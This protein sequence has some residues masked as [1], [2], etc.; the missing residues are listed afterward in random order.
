M[1]Y[2]ILDSYDL[3]VRHCVE[4]NG[5]SSQSP[6]NT[7]KELNDA[8]K[9]SGGEKP[10]TDAMMMSMSSRHL[11]VKEQAE[12]P[13]LHLIFHDE[14]DG[15]VA[16]RG[17][18]DEV[19]RA[20]PEAEL[21]PDVNEKKLS[22]FIKPKSIKRAAVNAKIWNG[23]QRLT[24]KQL[25]PIVFT[26]I[27]AL[28]GWVFTW[29]DITDALSITIA[30]NDLISTYALIVLGLICSVASVALL[31]AAKRE[32]F[33]NDVEQFE[34]SIA[35]DTDDTQFDKLLMGL[36]ESDFTCFKSGE[37]SSVYVI[38]LS[39]RAIYSKRKRK[40]I[41]RYLSVM[42]SKQ[43]WFVF[44]EKL[45]ENDALLSLDRVRIYTLVHLGGKKKRE[46]AKQVLEKTGV[47]IYES[48][49]NR[50]GVDAI[51]L[52]TVS[53]GATEEDKN[54]WKKKIEDFAASKSCNNIRVDTLVYFVADL[55]AKYHI[56]FTQPRLWQYLFRYGNEGSVVEELDREL[57]SLL[58][59]KDEKQ[60]F[61]GIVRLIEY[62]NA[63]FSKDFAFLSENNPYN[64]KESTEYVQLC[65]IKAL[66]VK[67]AD[68]DV[69]LCNIAL[70]ILDN[71]Y[72]TYRLVKNE[73]EYGAL[74]DFSQGVWGRVISLALG[75]FEEEN[76]RWFSP[77]I[78]HSFLNLYRAAPAH[79]RPL[80][81]LSTAE[82]L[83]A[84]R[85]NLILGPNIHG[86]EADDL[87]LRISEEER[88]GFIDPVY[89]HYLTVKFAAEETKR[90]EKATFGNTPN[91]FGIL[92]MSKSE[93]DEYYIALS[94]LG[95]ENVLHF[96]S[97]LYDTF[98]ACSRVLDSIKY[99]CY[100]LYQNDIAAK[101]RL[102]EN[103][104]YQSDLGYVSLI[105]DKMFSIIKDIYKEDERILERISEI[106]DMY[107]SEDER[108]NEIIL[109]ELAASE[110]SGISLFGYLICM[111]AR[112][113]GNREILQNMYLGIG[114]YLVRFIFLMY[115]ESATNDI[116]NSD[117]KYMVLI[118][119]TYADPSDAILGYLS[120]CSTRVKTDVTDGMIKSYLSEH[121]D[122]CV[123][124][125]ETVAENLRIDDYEGYISN[126]YSISYLSDE[127]TNKI[128][129]R[130]AQILLSTKFTRNE[131]VEL[132]IE[133]ATLLSEGKMSEKF[134]SLADG[135]L[136]GRLNSANPNSACIAYGEYIKLDE[137]RFLPLFPQ[138]AKKILSSSKVKRYD[139]FIRYLNNEMQTDT[140]TEQGGELI[141]ML[142]S[143]WFLRVC[144]RYRISHD[145]ISARRYLHFLIS[146]AKFFNIT[147]DLRMKQEPIRKKL[148]EEFSFFAELE[149]NERFFMRR[150][151]KTS[152]VNLI[153]YLLK[154][155]YLGTY[156]KK[157]AEGEA[158]TAEQIKNGAYYEAP[159]IFSNGEN[160]VNFKYL[161]ILEAI[162]KNE[163]DVQSILDEDAFLEKLLADAKEIIEALLDEKTARRMTERLERIHLSSRRF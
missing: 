161:E 129:R 63:E 8:K 82:F 85:S 37:R 143:D 122:E 66:R 139:F 14:K 134:A 2:S 64:G 135:E 24:V 57:T 142:I 93:R 48:E 163:Q 68:D 124:N 151:E 99:S 110:F 59:F 128:Y 106:H 138:V 53:S 103:T 71:I 41:R 39:D 157:S 112:I 148:E 6:C 155:S 108:I 111:I 69:R 38:T 115:H 141:A 130:L 36:N 70:I 11:K 116:N 98:C 9:R 33:W 156:G 13:S 91:Y 117:F 56:N 89:D 61:N 132:C 149:T 92:R 4:H 96:Y 152:I 62:I 72:E 97:N 154:T 67:K 113:K 52:K 42:E 79:E 140:Q 20:V 145:K 32:R 16:A 30:G 123:E 19:K 54:L 44:L 153:V 58:F 133:L 43:C 95:E 104:K 25:I 21:N 114:S 87:T 109:L 74:C 51:L 75:V 49:I 81:L 126:L 76:Y 12:K 50:Y 160:Y 29:L 144:Y 119:D 86:A 78:V 147:D 77:E 159:L 18:Y 34:E 45:S 102:P 22:S 7:V 55:S 137:K 23:S 100:G 84:A 46:L 158:L 121:I 127:Q 15:V 3:P 120:W 131:R 136:V 125:L 65:I 107:L 83:C 80:G 40:I 73:G 88:E 5:P 118:L 35:N 90:N 31:V 47:Q 146:A 105:L 94:R 60:D 150:W 26:A 28:A 1:N 10:L 101:Y 17:V 162:S 27:G